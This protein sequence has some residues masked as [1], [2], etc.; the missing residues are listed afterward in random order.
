MSAGTNRIITPL[1]VAFVFLTSIPTFAGKIIYVDDDAPGVNDGSSWE[2][3]YNYL[4]DALAAAQS[5]DMICVA[6]GIYNPDQCAGIT[7]GDKTATFQLKNDVAIKGGYAGFREVN[8]N[9]RDIEENITILSGD[10]AGDDIKLTNPADMWREQSRYDNS[11]HVVTGS[12]VDAN[13]ILDGFTITAGYNSALGA[14]MYN[15][16]GNPT[17]TNCTF[18]WNCAEWGGGMGNWSSSPQVIDCKFVSNGAMGG[19]G[20]DNVIDG[21]PILIN[22]TFSHNSGRWR[23]GGML[24]G[25]AGIGGS[26]NP[27]L[28]NCIFNGNSTDR[29][30]GGMYN[31]DS[32]PIVDNCTFTGNAAE[33]GGGIYSD[34]GSSPTLTNCILWNN[35]AIYGHEIYLSFYSEQ[36][37]SEITVSFSDVQGGTEYVYVETGSILN[38]EVGN[39]D[40]DPLFVVPGQWEWYSW[41]DG[42]YNLLE[43][44]PCIDTGDPNYVSGHTQTDLNGKP[45]IMGGR[46]DMGALE[47]SQP[48]PTCARIIPN[49]I[50]LKSKGKWI[51]A[52]LWL[53]EDY[54]VADINPN[55]VY[56]QEQVEAEHLL[57]NEQ[58]QVAIAKF[59]REQV[60]GIL[61][62]GENEL[63]ITAQL[64]DATVFEGTDV[65][66]VIYEGGGKLAKYGKA[67]NP[68][69]ADGATDVG[70]NA[71]L[72]WTTGFGAISHDVYFGR[73]SLPPFVG[74]QTATSFDPGLMYTGTRYYWR[75]DEVNKW[76]KT[77]GD[78]WS[79]TTTGPPPPPPPPP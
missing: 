26:V 20:I 9:V 56:L 36:Q 52:F 30:G 48:V 75:I 31:I 41:V 25:Y 5:G 8:P 22:C 70:T 32:S 34:R 13:A 17:V 42:D 27:I 65:I 63:K 45:R 28:I 35:K 64:T 2:D 16:D 11:I 19:G 74:N 3:A 62:I 43:A 59:S 61:I 71:D 78:L 37:P 14:G 53:P 18:T 69:P 66:K 76:G 15:K 10:L 58:E 29:F 7:P 21:I 60:Q 54:N 12:Y 47:F 72:S 38:W 6:E 24:N 77:T 73:T 46:I 68:N 4:Q 51:T 39:I 79:F 55:S 50:S 57:I 40:A 49:T 67:D 1:I 23:G 44:S 33:R